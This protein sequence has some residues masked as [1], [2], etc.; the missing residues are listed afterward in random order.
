MKKGWKVILGLFMVLGLA[1]CSSKG[2]DTAAIQEKIDHAGWKVELKRDDGTAVD[3]LYVHID[4]KQYF[5]LIR[6]KEDDSILSVDYKVGDYTIGYDIE[7]QKDIGNYLEN[8]NNCFNYNITDDKEDETLDESL[9][10][11]NNCSTIK[12]KK[13]KSLAE[14]RDKLLKDNNLSVQNLYDWAKWYY[15]NS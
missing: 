13:F 8:N 2:T 3:A 14:E 1:G 6:M 7:S 12:V 9:Q 5:S 11:I 4:D 15:E 10:S